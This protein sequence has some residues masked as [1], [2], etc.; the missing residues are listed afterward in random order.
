M[1]VIRQAWIVRDDLKNN[2]DRVYVFGDN[3]VRQGYGGQAKEMRGEP[4][5]FGVPTKWAPG[6]D[7][8]DFFTDDS[9]QD[10]TF[11]VMLYGAFVHLTEVLKNG[12]DVVIPKDGLG[13]GLSKLPEKAPKIAALIDSLI[14]KLEKDFGKIES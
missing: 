13:T 7:E 4:N 10:D 5:A 3:M 9:F 12:H 6:N 8:L 14:E 11:M 2:R 1:P